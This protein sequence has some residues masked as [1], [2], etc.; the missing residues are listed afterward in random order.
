MEK[1]TTKSNKATLIAAALII[2]GATAVFG[3]YA[4]SDETIPT[5]QDCPRLIHQELTDEQKTALEEARELLEAGDKEGAKEILDA[6][7]VKPPKG[8]RNKGQFMKNLTDEQKAAFEEARELREAGDIEGAKAI[9]EAA[10]IERP[11]M[12]GPNTEIIQS[13]TD[14]QKEM[15]QEAHELMKAGD[16]EGAKAIFEELGLERPEKRP[17]NGFGR[18]PGQR[19]HPQGNPTE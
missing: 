5:N 19:L 3:T 17:G 18:K 4:A 12:E 10:G 9:L 8:H 2:T 14:E 1:V 16:A 6:A 15:F 7:G 11:K 13:F